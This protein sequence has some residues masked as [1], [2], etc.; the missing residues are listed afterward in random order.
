ML[1]FV[2]W[3]CSDFLKNASKNNDH[4]IILFLNTFIVHFP[5]LFS[6]CNFWIITNNKVYRNNHFLVPEFNGNAFGISPFISIHLFHKYLCISTNPELWLFLHKSCS[7]LFQNIFL[8]PLVYN[9]TN[10]F[11]KENLETNCWFSVSALLMDLWRTS[12]KSLGASPVLGALL[13]VQPHLSPHQA[14]LAWSILWGLLSLARMS[15]G[16]QVGG[17]YEPY[18]LGGQWAL[19]QKGQL[20]VE[21]RWS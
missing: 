10:P 4:L 19:S 20:G 17:H 13:P 1:K 9:S 5:P 7:V 12:S 16:H 3:H 11:I 8:D 15:T 21:G 2:I 6:D 14:G 18:F